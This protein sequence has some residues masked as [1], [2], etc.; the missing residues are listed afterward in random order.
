MQ[1]FGEGE[2]VADEDVLGEGEVAAD[3]DALGEGELAADAD[4]GALGEASAT[5]EPL[6]PCHACL[7]RRAGLGPAA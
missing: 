5:H 6:C 4:E 7:R 1:E 3:E 2:V